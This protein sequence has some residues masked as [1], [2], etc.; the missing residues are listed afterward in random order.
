MKVHVILAIDGRQI[1]Q[2]I[3]ADSPDGVLVEAKERV[4]REI[5]FKGFF[6][7]AMSPLAFAQEAVRRYNEAYGKSCAL[8]A[9]AADFLAFGEETGHLIVLEP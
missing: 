4:A 6:I 1:D 2:I 3:E 7:R 5:G 8:P 9:T